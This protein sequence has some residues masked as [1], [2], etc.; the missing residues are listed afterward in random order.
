MTGNSSSPVG[1]SLFYFDHK[2]MAN[3]KDIDWEKGE[4][5]YRLGQ[6]SASEIGKQLSCATST[7]I[8]HMESLGV[9]RDKADE[10]KRRTREAIATKRIAQSNVAEIT[11]GDIDE[12]V[13]TNIA[14]V[15]SHRKDL[16]RLGDIEKKLLDEL[17]DSPTKLYLANFQGQ[18]IER[19][20]G[21]TVSEKASTLLSLSNVMAKRVEKQR[22]AFG[23]TDDQDS[24]SE[25]LED[26]SRNELIKVARSSIDG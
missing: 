12:A 21:L 3:K 23:I 1:Q 10:V 6:L 2:I 22:Q 16:Q 19:V 8:R 18:I 26:M 24:G 11:E 4:K 9:K 17:D 15:F 7:V 5:L 25:K 14:L 20:V 13:N